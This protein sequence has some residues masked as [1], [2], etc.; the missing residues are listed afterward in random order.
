MDFDE[1]QAIENPGQFGDDPGT[2]CF[3]FSNP[4]RILGERPFFTVLRV[5][6]PEIGGE[7]SLLRPPPVISEIDCYLPGGRCRKDAASAAPGRVAS[8]VVV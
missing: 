5:D 2:G 1:Q 8:R 3:P 7:G 6:Q 4:Q